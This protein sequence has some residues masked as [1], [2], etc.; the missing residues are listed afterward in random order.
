MPNEVQRQ[1]ELDVYRVVDS[2]PEAAYDDI[3]RLA[4]M[5]CDA[6]IALISLIDRD[7]QWF[8]ARTGLQVPET[9]REVAFCDHAIRQPD[10][11]MEVPDALNDERFVDNPLVTGEPNMRFYAGMPLVTPGGAAIGTVCV[12]DDRPRTLDDTQRAALESLARLTMNLMEATRRE[13]QLERAVRLEPAARVTAVAGASDSALRPYAIAIFQIQD[14]ANVAELQGARTI[15]RTL[16]EADRVLHSVLAPGDSIDRVTGSGEFVA[17]LH[18]DSPEAA[19]TALRGRFDA[20]ERELGTRVLLGF[21]RATSAD[22]SPEAVYLRAD[23]VLTS[24]KDTVRSRP[25]A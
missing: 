16:Q 2:L 24:A 13:R 8:K 14:F 15:E 6:P 25:P 23:A 4:S 18:G 19:L 17:L 21:A 7:R 12:I 22:E 5:L 9:P 20:I 11:L 1:R 3:A 10:R